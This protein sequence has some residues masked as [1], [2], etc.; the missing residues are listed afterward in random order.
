MSKYKLQKGQKFLCCVWV[1]NPNHVSR[2]KG[3]KELDAARRWTRRMLEGE[4]VEEIG[5]LAKNKANKDWP[6][7]EIERHKNPQRE[8]IK[9]AAKRLADETRSKRR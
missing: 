6:W 8:R 4:A 5:I 2:T 9:A 1:R 7:T 3:F